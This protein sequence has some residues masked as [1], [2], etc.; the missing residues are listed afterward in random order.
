M[1][2]N[3]KKILAYLM[4]FGS[5]TTGGA[6]AWE[7]GLADAA[8]RYISNETTTDNHDLDTSYIAFDA[9][10]TLSNDIQSDP[11]EAITDSI[12]AAEW[13]E[14]YRM[15][16]DDYHTAN[17]EVRSKYQRVYTKKPKGYRVGCIC[18]DNDRQDN[19]GTGA[20]SGHGGV[21]FWLYQ[22]EDGHLLEYP[23][24]N[25]KNHPSALTPEEL[26]S[27]TFYNKKRHKYESDNR[28]DDSDFYKMIMMLFI[29]ITVAYLAKLWW[30]ET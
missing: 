23:T 11:K 17:K 28:T 20:C 7:Y 30:Y 21:R 27:L 9:I 4:G 15:M 18:M 13:E 25:H 12:T 1:K 5:I 6:V 8:Y 16:E 14:Y 2:E 10:D 22:Q 24:T 29:C 19:K 26:S 3:G